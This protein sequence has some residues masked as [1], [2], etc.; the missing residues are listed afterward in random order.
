MKNVIKISVLHQR[1]RELGYVN[2]HNHAY[3]LIINKWPNT[4]NVSGLATRAVRKALK[5]GADIESIINEGL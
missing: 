4:L 2:A 1:A 3:E 5:N